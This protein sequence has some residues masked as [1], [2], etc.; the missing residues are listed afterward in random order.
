MV[1]RRCPG[2]RHPESR[3]PARPGWG[4]VPAAADAFASSSLR[5]R[6]VSG[7][8]RWICSPLAPSVSWND[9]ASCT[10]PFLPR[11]ASSR[12]SVGRG[13]YLP[14]PSRRQPLF[15]VS[16]AA[17][18]S[19]APASACKTPAPV[20]SQPRSA[21]EWRPPAPCKT[22]ALVRSQPRSAA[23]WRPPSL[24]IPSAPLSER[25]TPTTNLTNTSICDMLFAAP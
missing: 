18:R 23:E 9:G 17:Q 16:H 7:G 22:P 10:A 4:A 19:G 12:Q 3:P 20:R 14:C 5:P 6:I 8:G 11:F 21:A 15:V 2:W 13:G 1:H 24:P 25:E